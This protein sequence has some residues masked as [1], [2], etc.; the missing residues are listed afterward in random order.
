[1]RRQFGY[2]MLWQAAALLLDRVR[3]RAGKALL[4]LAWRYVS[5][6]MP[7][8]EEA[9]WRQTVTLP[10]CAGIGEDLHSSNVRPEARLQNPWLPRRAN[11][12][13]CDRKK[14]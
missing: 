2:S 9:A 8:A 5:K 12:E 1:M 14:Q 6:W 4:P 10:A 13:F 3:V 7:S 11:W